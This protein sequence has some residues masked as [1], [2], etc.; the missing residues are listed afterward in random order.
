MARVHA[1]IACLSTCT[2]VTSTCDS[3]HSSH[4]HVANIIVAR[5]P[6]APPASTIAELLNARLPPGVTLLGCG[7]S[8]AELQHLTQQQWASADV[9]I[10]WGAR[11][12]NAKVCAGHSCHTS[13]T[14]SSVPQVQH[15]FPPEASSITVSPPSFD[16]FLGW[17]VSACQQPDNTTRH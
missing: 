9:L 8:P 16:Q 4:L 12:P 7:Q 17:A 15:D 6:P 11:N 5:Y 13:C 1:H 2:P 14:A 3:A 10:V